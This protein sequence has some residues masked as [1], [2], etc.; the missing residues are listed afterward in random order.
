VVDRPDGSPLVGAIAVVDGTSDSVVTGGDGT[1]TIHDLPV[2]THMVRVRSVGF[3]PVSDVVELSSHSPQHV[4]IA[5]TTPARVPNS[6]LVAAHRLQAGYAR[7][8]FD[9]RQLDGAGQFLTAD[10]IADKHAQFFSLLLAGTIAV[11]SEGLG[12]AGGA[13][14]SRQATGSCIA[15]VLDGNRFDPSAGTDLDA[16]YRPDEIA[17]IEIY[18]SAVVPIEF[19][20]VVVAPPKGPMSVTAP[21]DNRP[22]ASGA[23]QPRTGTPV[24]S[25]I[26]ASAVVPSED[27]GTILADPRASGSSKLDAN[28]CTTVVVWTKSYL[29][30]PTR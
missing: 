5:L 14:T 11:Q 6:V 4:N 1:F 30:V 16:L 25:Q 21:S 2:G 13:L 22:G 27:Q 12:P 28:A 7:V 26:R 18:G 29:R 24:P 17:G 20:A 9:R 8:G 19:R 3:E 10:D 15:Y 23:P